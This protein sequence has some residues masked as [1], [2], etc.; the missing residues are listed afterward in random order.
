[1]AIQP[2]GP[3]GGGGVLLPPVPPLLGPDV[4]PRLSPSAVAPVLA[5]G[6]VAADQVQL[7]VMTEV[8]Q[9]LQAAATAGAGAEIE[10]VSRVCSTLAGTTQL[11]QGLSDSVATQI[12]GQLAAGQITADDM[13]ALAAS[14]AS[15]AGGTV[16]FLT[17][18]PPVAVPPVP[19][20]VVSTSALPETTPSAGG[21]NGIMQVT[22]HGTFECLPGLPYAGQLVDLWVQEDC[23][24]PNYRCICVN[25]A[26][27]QTGYL[28]LG[29]FQTP[30]S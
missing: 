2:G 18:G 1:M 29:D 8:Q 22:A 20:G 21:T 7:A 5:A 11:F 15:V 4:T 26:F 23:A 10:C 30:E 27:P 9:C 17:A 6:Q 25:A 19:A 28:N 12:L 16:P 3:G 14:S 13:C 24:T